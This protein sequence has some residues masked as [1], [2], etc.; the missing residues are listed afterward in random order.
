MEMQECGGLWRSASEMRNGLDRL[1]YEQKLKAVSTQLNLHKI[2]STPILVDKPKILNQRYRK[3]GARQ[4]TY[5]TVD[6]LCTNVK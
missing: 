4:F 2:I 5:L 3:E 6:K 1:N